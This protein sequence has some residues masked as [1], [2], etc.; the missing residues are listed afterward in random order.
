MKELEGVV[1]GTV[2]EIDARLGRVKVNFPW[3]Q[4]AQE[5]HWAPIAS[6]LSGKERGARFMPE[7]NDEVLVAFDHGQYEHP[8][9]IGFLWNGVDKAPDDNRHNRLI[10]TPGGHELRFEDK[11]GDKRVVLKTKDG[12]RLSLDDKDR[13]I[14]LESKGKHKLEIRDQEGKVTVST[15]SGGKVTLDNLPGRATIEVA[16]NKIVITPAG[17]RI[18]ATAGAL[19]IQSSTA[20]SIVATGA[21][22]VTSTAAM[23]VQSSA[24]MNVTS[25]AAI[26]LTT[27]GVL[28]V[29]A[30]LTNFSGVVRATLVQADVIA[31]TTYTPGF[32]N[33]L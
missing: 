23:T 7:K 5:S 8:Y 4:P 6:L 28:N 20:T 30:P 10:V 27:A 12:H 33:L 11:D 29:A 17:I 14:T 3:L 1:V 32:G 31:G 9:V 18:E 21:M 25:A 19:S 15:Q 26:N 16:S 2:S 13:S 22:S 24:V